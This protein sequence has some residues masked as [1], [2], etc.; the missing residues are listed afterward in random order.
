MGHSMSSQLAEIILSEAT[1]RRMGLMIVGGGGVGLQQIVPETS[2][3]WKV[4]AR[5]RKRQWQQVQYQGETTR[6]G[7]G[8]S[9]LVQEGQ[10]EW[11]QWV[12]GRGRE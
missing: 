9:S 11:W 1:A 3:W 8:D 6:S 4:R 2:R 7:S 10:R 5:L 12:S